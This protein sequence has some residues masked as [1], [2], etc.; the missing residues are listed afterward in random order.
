MGGVLSTSIT[1]PAVRRGTHPFGWRSF[2]PRPSG[3][4]GIELGDGWLRVAKRP[5]RSGQ[6]WNVLSLDSTDGD[7][8]RAEFA[9]ARVH[10]G[11]ASL[12]LTLPAVDV[13][14]LTIP[15]EQR[16][17]LDAAV[18]AHADRRLGYPIADA[19]IDYATL[20]ARFCR[21]PEGSVGVLVYAV[22]RSLFDGVL[23]ALEDAGVE[24]ETILTPAFALAPLAAGAEGCRRLLVT[25]SESAVSIAVIEEGVVLI[26]RLLSWGSRQLVHAVS[27]AL[28]LTPSESTQLL[29]MTDDER[30]QVTAQEVV[31]DILARNYQELGRE[32]R[33]CLDYCASFL[34]HRDLD[35]I[36]LTGSV[37]RYPGFTG[38]LEKCLGVRALTLAQACPSDLPDVP[39]AF[40][41]A[42]GAA[43]QH[44]GLA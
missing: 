42:I 4:A 2:L 44:E 13:F 12:A 7:A 16:N 26:E 6:A 39:P 34:H 17:D 9:R 20:P 31:R 14:P 37:A 24:V 5:K 27:A 38:S 18:L 11:R 43:L 28:D 29:A 33:S 21:Q 36:V 30:T 8:F 3:I 25:T 23:D 15:H 35:A 22:E 19:S 32:A 40:A 41:V 10:A 1:D